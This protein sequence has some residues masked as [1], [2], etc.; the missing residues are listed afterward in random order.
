MELIKIEGGRPLSGTVKIDSAKNSTVA[1]IPASIL[2]ESPVTL[3]N[4]PSIVDVERLGEMIEQLGGTYRYDGDDDEDFIIDPTNLQ[5]IP[6]LEGP[7]TQLRASYY[8]LGALLAKFKEVKIGMPGGC[9]LGPRPIDLHLKGFEALGATIEQEGGTIYMRA[10]RLK[11]AKI[12]LD[13]P[14]VGATINIM[15]AASKAEGTTVIE[16][17]AKEPEIV[18]LS[19]LLNNMGAKIRGAGTDEIRI[20]GVDRLRGTRHA[21]IPDRIEAGTYIAL[22]AA[23]AEEVK[24]DNIIP[25]HLDALISKLQEMGVDIEINTDSVTVRGGK[26]LKAVDFKTSIYPG[27][28]TDLQQ[29]LVTLVTQSD[30]VGMVEDTIYSDRFRNCYELNKMGA[31]IRVQGN[32]AIIQG[33]TPLRGARVMATDLRAGASLVIAALIAEGVTEIGNTY[34]IDRGYSNIEE[35]LTNLGAKIWREKE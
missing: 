3:E 10:E 8:F 19:N 29:P 6:L 9:Y 16:N 34:H 20:Q 27:L 21:I 15:I 1:L 31:N 13:F 33:A 22:A 26:A 5:N 7:V 4:I 12:Y 17:A 18:D 11:G 24:I 2:A 23:A 30:G 32:S 25:T 14:S 35:K 28:A